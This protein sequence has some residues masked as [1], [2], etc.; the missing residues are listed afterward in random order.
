MSRVPAA[1]LLAATVP[2]RA[3][4]LSPR[5][6]Q[7]SGVAAS[8]V[9]A[10]PHACMAHST[11]ALQVLKQYW[12]YDEFRPGQA[13]TIE[14]LLSGQDALVIMA[15]GS[16]KSL[17]CVCAEAWERGSFCCGAGSA[18]RRRPTSRQLLTP[19]SDVAAFK[20]RRSSPEPARLW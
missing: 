11:A 7:L 14:A 13:E 4:S 3:A 19:P 6:L 1:L 16:G 12:G 2:A 8:A 9:A 18:A 5:R 10:P 15:T 17:W 20:C